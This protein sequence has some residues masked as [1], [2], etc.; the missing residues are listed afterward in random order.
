[1]KTI[2][3][4]LSVICFGLMGHS[5]VQTKLITVD[6]NQPHKNSITIYNDGNQLSLD[7]ESK[8]LS[9]KS[10]DMISIQLVNGN[11]FKYSY[12]IDTKEML[13]HSTVDKTEQNSSFAPEE[14]DPQNF[15]DG[16]ESLTTT[17]SISDLEAKNEALENKIDSLNNEVIAYYQKIKQEDVLLESIFFNQRSLF[18]KRV[19]ILLLTSE[20]LIATLRK[21]FSNNK[22]FKEKLKKTQE[23]A[24][25]TKEDILNKFYSFDI[26]QYTLPIDIQGKNIDAIEF[27]I[28]RF[29]K[30]TGKEDANFASKGYNI[31]IRGG[32]KIDVS[33][34]IF[35]TSLYDHEFDKREDLNT[36]GNKIIMLKNK[37]D[38]DFAF[39]T[40]INTYMRMKSW[41]VPTINFGTALTTNQKFQL[42]LGFGF[43]LG[44][45]ER[46]I[47]S[48][49][50]SMGKVNRIAD[51][52]QVNGSYNLGDTG[53]IP[54]QNQF[55]FGHFFGVTYNLSK[56]KKIS[57]EKGLE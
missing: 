1:M 30:E 42:L 19:K 16:I 14:L 3:N 37:G 22:T 44:K 53:T 43:I 28:Q 23:K 12:K 55:K 26:R 31:W 40:T 17:D 35:F 56:V 46:I 54:T 51:G 36:A 45:Q 48:T 34:G 50:L 32:I 25:K 2:I 4:I 10:R 9:V 6:L 47:F 41:F 52:Y 33:A 49:G 8:W 11:P 20:Q 38:Y 24:K 7:C 29:D 18:L 57:Y 39:G 27:K 5:Q 13:L 15:N 21:Q